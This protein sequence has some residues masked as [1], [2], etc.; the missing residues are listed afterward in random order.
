V[1]CVCVC[2]MIV[3]VGKEEKGWGRWVQDPAL[4]HEP[5]VLP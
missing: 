3:Q 5:P 4:V 1:W 2:L